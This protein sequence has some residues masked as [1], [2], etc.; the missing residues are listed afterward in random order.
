MGILQDLIDEKIFE[1]ISVFSA[2][3]GICSGIC[4]YKGIKEGSILRGVKF[5]FLGFLVVSFFGGAS[6]TIYIGGNWVSAPWPADRVHLIVD[7]VSYWIIIFS[8]YLGI[9]SGIGYGI[10]EGIKKDSILKGI[11]FAFLGFFVVCI[12]GGIAGFVV[13]EAA[14]GIVSAVMFVVIVGWTFL[15]PKDVANSLSFGW[16]F[17]SIGYA[18]SVFIVIQI[19]RN[20]KMDRKYKILK[21]LLIVP[22]S[23]IT[24]ETIMITADVITKAVT[25][26]L[27]FGWFFVSAV[28]AISIFTGIWL[29]L[30]F[31]VKNTTIQMLITYMFIIPFIYINFGIIVITVPIIVN[32][33]AM[34]AEAVFNSL[35]F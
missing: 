14:G 33:T 8:F 20:H 27:P 5:A 16:F 25:S 28:C 3:S 31:N 26:F 17:V 18:M 1:L 6:V 12:V 19:C 24:F 7:E 4:I 13:S 22:L 23:Y 11:G 29:R 32:T 2:I 34:I 30:D 35:P 9:I 10:Y 15:N 21:M